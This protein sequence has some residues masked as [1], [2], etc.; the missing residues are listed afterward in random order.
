MPLIGWIGIAVALWVVL[1][2]CVGFFM[3]IGPQS[4][5]RLKSEWRK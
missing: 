5:A 1:V 4:D 3:K 2:I